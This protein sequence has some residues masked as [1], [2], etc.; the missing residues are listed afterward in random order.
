MNP[1]FLN[2]KSFECHHSVYFDRAFNGGFTVA[3]TQSITVKT[4]PEIFSIVVKW[5]YTGKL[6]DDSKTEG[7]LTD[8]KLARLWI[9]RDELLM[10]QLQ[11]DA[12]SFYY[13]R[14]IAKGPDDS[15]AS[16]ID[17]SYAN[18]RVQ[19]CME[20]HYVWKSIEKAPHAVRRYHNLFPMA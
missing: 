6:C 11:N 3:K 2:H 1:K 4:G 7:E 16:D 9:L 14:T 5:M 17:G 10:P 20:E 13:N 8:L 12:I 15:E 19:I 18:T